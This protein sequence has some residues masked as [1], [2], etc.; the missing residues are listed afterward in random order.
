MDSLQGASSEGSREIQEKTELKTSPPIG[1]RRT[2][3]SAT[4]EKIQRV[5]NMGKGKDTGNQTSEE[6]KKT[7]RSLPKLPSGKKKL[8]TP[9][10]SK[11]ASRDRRY[12]FCSLYLYTYIYLC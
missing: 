12:L 6:N 2:Y 3:S 4:I 7:E 10:T 11:P 8:P 1:M 9:P 5:A